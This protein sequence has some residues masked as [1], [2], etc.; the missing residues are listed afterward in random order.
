MYTATA[1]ANKFYSLLQCLVLAHALLKR[2]ITFSAWF[3]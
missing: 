2:E 3:V 1:P